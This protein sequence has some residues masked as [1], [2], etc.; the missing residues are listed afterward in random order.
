MRRWI[1][2]FLFLFLQ[3]PFIQNFLTGTIYRGPAKV[4]CT[5]TLNCYSCP[6][7]LFSCPIGTMQFLIEY[8]KMIPAYA[9][10]SLAIFGPLF[11]RG[12]CAYA[13]P[14]GLLQDLLHRLSPFRSQ[15]RIIPWVRQAKWLV[16]AV[17]VVIV[18]YWKEIPAFCAW[19][20]PAGTLQAGIP[21]V[22]A[23]D[24]F[25]TGIGLTFAW[26]VLLL[27]VIVLYAMREQRPFCRYLCPLGLF[28]GLFNRISMLRIARDRNT[29]L[30]CGMCGR[31]CPMGLELPREIN[32]LDCIKCGTCIKGC[33]PKI[34][35][36]S[37]KF[38]P[39]DAEPAPDKGRTVR[40]QN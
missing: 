38:T 25:R 8:A 28:L 35:A 22:L 32:A 17:F 7:A 1:T 5:G 2:Q 29:C 11:G 31:Q 30:S 14:F 15:V 27:A 34:R 13:C 37:W 21:I 40:T 39:F 16:F 36:L 9:I 33:P 4:V 12:P 6:A 23:N 18:P 20:C 10:G 19:I 26:K 24:S 3:N